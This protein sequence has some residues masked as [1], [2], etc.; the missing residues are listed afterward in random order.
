MID[1][2]QKLANLLT[3]FSTFMNVGTKLSNTEFASHITFHALLTVFLYTAP[4]GGLTLSFG[5][6]GYALV[7]ELW[8]DR[9]YNDFWKTKDGRADMISRCV[10]AILPYGVILCFNL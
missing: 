7:K 1:V 2:E 4:F 8:I 9:H 5:S 10:G 3:R 6:L